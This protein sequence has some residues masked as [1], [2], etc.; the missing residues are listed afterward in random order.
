MLKTGSI[1]TKLGVATLP[2]PV[3]A[4]T[5]MFLMLF[6]FCFESILGLST[7]ATFGTCALVLLA[8]LPI[9]LAVTIVAL[10]MNGMLVS[11]LLLGSML[12][13]DDA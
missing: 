12:P 10:S 8:D 1:R 9:D 2:R 4:S 5:S 6:A 11:L 3:R 7:A 13:D